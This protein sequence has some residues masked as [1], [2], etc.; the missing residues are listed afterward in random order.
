MRLFVKPASIF[1]VF[2]LVMGLSFESHHQMMSF[3]QARPLSLLSTQRY[4]KAFNTL[5]MICK[6]CDNVGGDC[7]S[8]DSAG[9]VVDRVPLNGGGGD[10][11]A[12]GGVD[13]DE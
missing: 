10:S 5:G 9:G 13:D 7:K 3:A 1:W 4:A 8:G 12:G 2:V 6:C 11:V